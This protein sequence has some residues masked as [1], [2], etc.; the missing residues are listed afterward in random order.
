MTLHYNGD[1]IAVM[2]DRSKVPVSF[3]LT[4]D[5]K[6]LLLLLKQKMGI[7]KTDVVEVAIRKLAQSEGV[8][9]PPK[10]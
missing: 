9:L 2:S 1:T 10:K 6:E 8:Q 5:A 7:D 4:D 3:R